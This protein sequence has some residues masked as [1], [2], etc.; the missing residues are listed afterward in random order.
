M[1]TLLYTFAQNF[2]IKLQKN[3]KNPRIWNHINCLRGFLKEKN[4]S[5]VIVLDQYSA[6]FQID[7]Y[8]LHID[9][10]NIALYKK[11]QLIEEG[12]FCRTMSLQFISK[13]LD[14]VS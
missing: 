6:K 11:D 3:R 14:G 4:L 1:S 2:V 9:G 8:Y 12:P 10:T 7:E 5:H 13:I